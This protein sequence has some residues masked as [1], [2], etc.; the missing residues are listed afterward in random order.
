MMIFCNGNELFYFWTGKKNVLFVLLR[1]IFLRY[2]D[3]ICT[4]KKLILFE[5]CAFRRGRQGINV[6]NKSRPRNLKEL[7][8]DL[9]ACTFNER[10]KT[11]ISRRYFF[12]YRICVRSDRYTHNIILIN[13][14]R[15]FSLFFFSLLLCALLNK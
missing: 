13:A 7:T 3:F 12:M 8:A 14:K 11:R 5:K 15:S 2:W 1:T 6:E 4:K 9:F 10:G